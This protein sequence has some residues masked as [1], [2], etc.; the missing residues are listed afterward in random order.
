MPGTL[1]PL[2]WAVLVAYFGVIAWCGWWFSRRTIR[3][4]QDYFLGARTMPVWAVAISV[5]ATSLSAATF[6]GVPQMSY[7]GDLAYLSHTIGFLLAVVFVAVFFIP[8]FYREGVTSIYELL[9]HRLGRGA[10]VAAS[11]AFM[12]GRV[13]ASGARVYIAAIPLALILFGDAGETIPAGQL[14]AAIWV[15]TVVAVA[16]TLV[17]GIASVIWTE[18]AQTSVLVAAVVA[19]IVVLL[20]RIGAGPGEIVAALAQGGEGGRSKLTVFGATG[21]SWRDAYSLPSV[22]VAFAV[23]GVAAYGTDH[24]LA[25]RML[26]C[27]TPVRGGWSAIM[28]ILLSVPIIGLFLVV[29]LLLFVFYTRPDLVGERAPGYSPGDTRKV[30]LTFILREMPSGVTGLMIAGLFSVGISSLSS[31]LNAMAATFVKDV[32][33][34]LRPGRAEGAY[35]TAGRW[36]VV[37]WGVVL[38]AFACGCVAWQT[39]TKTTLVDFALGVMTFAY[40]G[41]VGVFLAAVFTRRGNTASAV[42]AIVAGAG[43]V[44]AFQ[45]F[46]WNRVAAW[47]CEGAAPGPPAWPWHLVAGAAVAL[48]VC[49]IGPRRVR[50]AD[51]APT[52]A[53]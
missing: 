49:C 38:G 14:F 35:V 33:V 48:G 3:G 41:L 24:D 36:A 10:K 37:G 44:V 11:S 23:F 20:G 45:P 26:T 34:H 2:D 17:G 31:A 30:F 15:M 39:S 8:V 18:V 7:T 28:A 27:R 50:P 42:A 21:F 13:L 4:T 16:Y 32:Y 43:V 46:A 5:I 29:G 22:V 1:A 12:G 25:Q 6:I 40:A 53:T 51:P 9:E 47:V 19:A 52:T